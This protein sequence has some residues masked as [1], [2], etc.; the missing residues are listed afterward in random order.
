MYL[1]IFGFRWGSAVCASNPER[2]YTEGEYELAGEWGIPRRIFL[3]S[4]ESPD[5]ALPA[6]L[7]G[8][9][10]NTQGRQEAFR[11]RVG[12]RLVALVR[13]PQ[14]LATA[15]T[16][17][18]ADLERQTPETAGEGAAVGSLIGRRQG[19]IPVHGGE[20]VR[21]AVK[22]D[23][24]VERLLAGTAVRVTS[25]KGAGGVGKTILAELVCRDP[26]IVAAFLGG[27]GR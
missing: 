17:A 15:I 21:R 6:S 18:L 7:L 25:L 5:L 27:S 16:A 8:Y 12:E 11:A 14:H 19:N 3:L 2:S 26:R 1:G 24:T 23:E 9:D 20:M 10:K 22:I 13:S 4:D